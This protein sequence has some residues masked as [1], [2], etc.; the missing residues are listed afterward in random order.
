MVCDQFQALSGVAVATSEQQWGVP[1]GTRVG[2]LADPRG[3]LCGGE[4]GEA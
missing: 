3:G 4:L 2:I 1:E